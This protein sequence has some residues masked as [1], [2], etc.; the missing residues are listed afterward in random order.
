MSSDPVLKWPLCSCICL[1][2][3][4]I[5]SSG[6]PGTSQRPPLSSACV[7]PQVVLSCCW[8]DGQPVTQPSLLAWPISPA[9]TSVGLCFSHPLILGST[10][11]APSQRPGLCR[12][13][14]LCLNH[15]AF[16]FL[17]P[18]GRWPFASQHGAVLSRQE[19][20]VVL[21]WARCTPCSLS[22]L[23]WRSRV[24]ESLSSRSPV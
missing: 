22:T 7:A 3:Q 18:S 8:G 24:T 10:C 9:G 15:P 19:A 6:P 13:C 21:V 5:V 12:R 23:S 14:C 4:V 20:D 2:A 16:P 17:L 1:L 11:P